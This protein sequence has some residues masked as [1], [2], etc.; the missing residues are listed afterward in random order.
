[1]TYID[2][3]PEDPTMISRRFEDPVAHLKNIEQRIKSKYFD[4]TI[5]S[6]AAEKY[7]YE[8]YYDLLFMRNILSKLG[9]M[10]NISGAPLEHSAER[11]VQKV[12]QRIKEN[13]KAAEVKNAAQSE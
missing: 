7:L 10:S 11:N 5:G 12:V 1:M 8:L 3:N 9:V 13:I 4:L 2:H 6:G